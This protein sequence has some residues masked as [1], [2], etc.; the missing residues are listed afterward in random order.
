MGRIPFAFSE[1]F[2]DFIDRRQEPATIQL[3]IRVSGSIDERRLSEALRAAA[4]VHPMMQV[5]KAAG[6]RLFRPAQWELSEPDRDELVRSRECADERALAALRAELCSR[7]IDLTHAPALRVVIARRP[8]GDSLLFSISHMVTDGIGALRFIRSAARAYTGQPDRVPAIDPLAARDLKRQFGAVLA[9]RRRDGRRPRPTL[10]RRSYI[11]VDGA[12]GQPGYGLVQSPLS[13]ER[14]ARLDARR[15][16]ATVTLNDLLIASIH[17]AIA[18]WNA[19]HDRP[20]R[21]LGLIAPVNMRPAE[22]REEVIANLVM[23]GHVVSTPQLR[24]DP[25]LLVDAVATQMQRIK[26]GEEFAATLGMPAWVRTMLLAYFLARGKRKPGVAAVV[27]NLGRIDEVPYFGLEAGEVT[28]LWFSAPS[29]MPTGLA[30]GAI[31]IGGHL[32]ITMRYRRALF[33]EAAAERFYGLVL[34]NLLTLGGD[35]NFQAEARS[36]AGT[37]SVGA[38]AT[39]RAK[40]ARLVAAPKAR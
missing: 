36:G 3:E 4:A 29:P 31:T 1:E 27:S 2:Y 14:T 19:E 22:W 33:S 6:R 28:E 35:A 37:A 26:S 15:F 7:P 13:P 18:A 10:G 16:G 8:G 38:T 17:L 39:H 40:I 23:V 32:H 5:T 25:Q 9:T 11:A 30:I 21:V 24:S 34:D 12:D 20:C